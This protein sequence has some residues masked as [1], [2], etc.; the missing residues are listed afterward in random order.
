MCLTSYV[1]VPLRFRVPTFSCASNTKV[2][3]MKELS[4]IVENNGNSFC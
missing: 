1:A 3:K 2:F 4:V